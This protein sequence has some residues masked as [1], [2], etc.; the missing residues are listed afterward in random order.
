M[1]QDILIIAE[2]NAGELK[3]TTLELAA[4][5]SALA[6]EVGGKVNA[7]ILGKS[8]EAVA[9]ALG[10]YGVSA[11]TV[12][13]IGEDEHFNSDIVTSVLTDFIKEEAVKIVLVSASARTREYMPRVAMRLNTGLIADC[14]ALAWQDDNLLARHP[15]YAGKALVDGIVTGSPQLVL[16]RPNAFGVPEAGNGVATVTVKKIDPP[17][18]RVVVKERIVSEQAEVDLT[19]ADIIVSGGRAL[20]SADNFKFIRELAKSIGGS[21][22]ASRAAV[23]AGYIGHEHQVGQTGKTVNPTLYIACGISG[24]IQHLAGMQTSRYIVAINKDPEAPIFSKTDFGIVA[25][26]F[27]ILPVLTEQIKK[28]KAV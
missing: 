6:G 25:D 7:V 5:A 16:L 15:V 4:K 18:P 26:L 20:G 13:D 27:S 12:L 1:S 24:A 14:V 2:H 23:D 9:P 10:E 8:A 28:V 3:R 21:V 17:T 22:G 19:E 11:V